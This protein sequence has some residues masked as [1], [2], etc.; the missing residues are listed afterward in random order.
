[1]KHILEII[2][3]WNRCNTLS[4]FLCDTPIN[5]STVGTQG[6]KCTNIC[7]FHTTSFYDIPINLDTVGTHGGKY[8]IQTDRLLLLLVSVR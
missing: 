1:M 5:I 7:S 6:G 2:V 8:T 3:V 4:Y